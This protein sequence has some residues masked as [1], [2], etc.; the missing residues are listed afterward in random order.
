ML[1]ILDDGCTAALVTGLLMARQGHCLQD[2]MDMLDRLPGFPGL[3]AGYRMQVAL[4]LIDVWSLI[5]GG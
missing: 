5:K 1:V 4:L 3:S 2:S